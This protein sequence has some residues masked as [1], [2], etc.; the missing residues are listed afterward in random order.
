MVDE[1]LQ[2]T[3]RSPGICERAM[4]V[5]EDDASGIATIRQLPRRSRK[6]ATGPPHRAQSGQPRV[7]QR[8]SGP[9]QL[10]QQKSLIKV[11]VVGHENPPTEVPQQ[12]RDDRLEGGRAEYVTRPDSMPLGSTNIAMR[13]DQS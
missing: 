1:V 10:C 7:I 3:R 8:H 5:S 11:D 13:I 4:G 2:Q 6:Q 12:P 9:T